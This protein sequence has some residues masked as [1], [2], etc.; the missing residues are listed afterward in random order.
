[1]TKVLVL[2]DGCHEIEVI[3]DCEDALIKMSLVANDDVYDYDEDDDCEVTSPEWEYARILPKWD[4]IPTAELNA[5]A[6]E[7]GYEEF[8]NKYCKFEGADEFFAVLDAIQQQANI[9]LT[10]ALTAKNMKLRFGLTLIAWQSLRF[11]LTAQPQSRD[12]S[13]GALWQQPH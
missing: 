12:I 3:V 8:I 9:L 4:N 5:E 7:L 10:L 1:M 11:T 2:D 13:F 6:A